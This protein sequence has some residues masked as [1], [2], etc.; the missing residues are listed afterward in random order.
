MITMEIATL[1]V[2]YL[3][4]LLSAQVLAG[5]TAITFFV[6]FREDIRGLLKRVARIRLPGG[7]EFSTTQIERTNEELRPR[8][9]QPPVTPPDALTLPANLTLTPEQVKTFGEAF[10]A[11]RARAALWEYRYLNYFLAHSTQRVF[12]WLAALPVRTTTSMFDAYWLPVIPSAA[13]RRTIIDALQAHTLIAIDGE[14]IE[15]TP[16]GKEYLQWRGPMPNAT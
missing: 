10:S 14:V 5:I 8:G 2:E 12:D 13:E 15:V 3:K 7:S 9:E 16:K 1:V 4:V 11:E 6:L